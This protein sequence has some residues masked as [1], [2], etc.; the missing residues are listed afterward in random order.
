MRN[1]DPTIRQQILEF[2]KDIPMPSFLVARELHK[3]YDDVRIC[4]EQL[5]KEGEIQNF[6]VSLLGKKEPVYYLN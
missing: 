5:N 3:P 6:E 4:L 2:M 1:M